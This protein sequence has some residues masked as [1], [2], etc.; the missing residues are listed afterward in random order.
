VTQ[1]GLITVEI[2]S[3]QD[4]APLADWMIDSYKEAD[5]LLTFI[6]D[7]KATLKTVE[8]QKSRCVGYSERF[9]KTPQITATGRPSMTLTLII[10]AEKITINGAGPH[11]NNWDDKRA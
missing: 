5:G 9:D 3:A 2:V 8:F 4:D 7:K 11:D 6:D 10:S 1:G